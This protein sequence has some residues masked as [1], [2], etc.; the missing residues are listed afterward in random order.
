MQHDVFHDER[1]GRRC[2]WQVTN[3][4]LAVHTAYGAKG[5]I[6]FWGAFVAVLTPTLVLAAYSL[7]ANHF[8]LMILVLLC[9]WGFWTSSLSPSGI[10]ML[11]SMFAAIAFFLLGVYMR[12][13]LLAYSSMLPG[14]T[15]FASCSILGTTASYLTDTLRNSKATFQRLVHRGLLKATEIPERHDASKSHSHRG[16]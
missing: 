9:F 16:R 6:T 15:W 14:F 2:D 13:K 1:A 8:A 7:Y 12:N 11:A 5:L 10:G 4:S 3:W